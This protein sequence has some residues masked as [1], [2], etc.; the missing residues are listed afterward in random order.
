[1]QKSAADLGR[2]IRDGRLDPVELTENTI[3]EIDKHPH[4]DT[5]FTIVTKERA[6]AEAQAAKGRQSEGALLG[7]LDGVPISW[8]DLFDTKGIVT[9][10]G[11]PLLKGRI[12]EKDCVVLDRATQQ[13]LVC[14]GKTHMSELAFSGLG[15]NPNA[16]TPPNINGADLNPGGSS[17]GAAAS[18]AHGLVSIGIGSDTGGSVRIPAAYNNLVGLKTTATY[19]PNDGVV[20]LCAG[21]DTVGPLTNTV[22]DAALMTSIM[23]GQ[24][25]SLPEPKP[26]SDCKFF[27]CKTVVMEG[28]D[29]DQEEGFN[30]AIE[31]LASAG[32]TI[33]YGEIEAY[34]DILPL[35][36]TLFPY[37]AWQQW[38]E[39]IEAQPDAMFQGVKNR[40]LSGKDLTREE[41]DQAWQAMVELRETYNAQTADY[42]AVLA[43]SVCIAPRNV[44]DLIND[45][46]YF[47]QSNLLVLRNTR[48]VNMFGL[49]ALTLPTSKP[50]SG[51]M[52]GAKP[53]GERDLVSIGLSVEME[54][55]A[56]G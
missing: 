1:M 32:A 19:L 55:A 20:P 3:S 12:P 33:E 14:V 9:E 46:E 52:L 7:P 17:S 53:F 43:P 48:F 8:K 11:S 18:V 5:I 2:Q 22:E 42:D 36:P 25:A 40:F 45:L 29:T 34:N 49:C 56:Q 47:Q 27:V 16:A 41:Y 37:E 38:G 54:L 26:L 44:N 23:A 39:A 28:L 24:S 10:A 51:L 4:R 31:R 6:L 15:I 13:G 21:F 35:G 50:A 30:L